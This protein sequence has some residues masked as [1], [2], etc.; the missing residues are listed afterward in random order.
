MSA[1][2]S[3]VDMIIDHRLEPEIL[4]LTGPGRA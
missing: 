3:Q 2:A 4:L 1:P